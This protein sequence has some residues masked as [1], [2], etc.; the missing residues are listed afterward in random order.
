[1]THPRLAG[2]MLK[3][4]S[5]LLAPL[6]LLLAPSPAAAWWEYGHES[7]A[8]IAALEVKPQTRAAIARL[9]ARSGELDTPT[10]PARTI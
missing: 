8:T 2:T 9:L 7:V 4:L 10:C 1:M 5:A 3:R 6:F